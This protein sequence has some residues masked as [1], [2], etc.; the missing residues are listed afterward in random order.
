MERTHVILFG[1]LSLRRL[2]ERVKQQLLGP[3]IHQEPFI[4][5]GLMTNLPKIVIG[6]DGQFPANR[7]LVH[8]HKNSSNIGLN[9]VRYFL[10]CRLFYLVV[11]LNTRQYVA[12][13]LQRCLVVLLEVFDL[14]MEELPVDLEGKDAG[15]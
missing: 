13:N 8:T 2:Q 4:I 15:G 7:G 9:H 1:Q 5:N 3:L 14:C 12:Q 11:L 10:S 6:L